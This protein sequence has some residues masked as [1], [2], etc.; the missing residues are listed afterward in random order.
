MNIEKIFG[1]SKEFSGF[2]LA[3]MEAALKKGLVLL[4]TLD[5]LDIGD[6]IFTVSPDKKICRIWED[7]EIEV[8]YI[9]TISNGKEK[10]INFFMYQVQYETTE[11]TFVNELPSSIIEILQKQALAKALEN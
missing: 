6:T 4:A 11:L 2:Q 8:G 9:Y 10:E 1:L 5:T 3:K 7:E